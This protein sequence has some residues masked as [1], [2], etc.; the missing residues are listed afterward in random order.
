VNTRIHHL[1][2]GT[3]HPRGAFG[4]KVSPLRLVAHV[5][6][7]EREEGLVLV[8]T[9]FGTEDVA[10][11]ARLG[12][13]YLASYR[14]ALKLPETALRQVE[15]L[16]FSAADVRDIVLT[17]MDFD[18]TG[19]LADFPKA[20]VHV[21]ATEHLA[22]EKPRTLVEKLRYLSADWGHHPDWR[23]H[24]SGGDDWFGFEG[25]RSVG[26]DV[27]LVPLR[28]HSRGH[29]GVAVR[30]DDGGWLL[31]A[32]DS[33]FWNGEVATPPTYRAGLT[34]LQKLTSTDEK[35]R[36]QNQARLRELR[37]AHPEITIFCSHDAAEFERLAD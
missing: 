1:N 3:V 35:T 33:Y 5:L 11:P 2:C 24:G 34:T 13:A 7:V 21:D 25:V 16:G 15:A 27:V 18:H 12:R 31:H 20:R 29:S 19:G 28:G 14:P 17:H 8:D 9:G 32:G 22:A 6:L 26:D 4:G 36:V 37:A 10:R 23:L 30:R